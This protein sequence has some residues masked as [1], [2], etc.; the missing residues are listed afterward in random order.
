MNSRGEF[1]RHLPIE[2]R[3]QILA[4]NGGGDE[5]AR[6]LGILPEKTKSDPKRK[7]RS[8]RISFAGITFASEGEYKAF[9]Y[10]QDRY[11]AVFCHPKIALG[12][13]RHMQPDFI[14]VH[15]VYKDGTYH[16]ESLDYKGEWRGK[17][18]NKRAHAER[19]W[20]VRASWLKDKTGI[21]VRI[22]TN[23]TLKLLQR[24]APASS[25]DTQSDSPDVTSG[26]SHQQN[27]NANPPHDVCHVTGTAVPKGG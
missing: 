17:S 4:E 9:L 12:D 26:F 19:D 20:K 8:R 11:P 25:S 6:Q 24:S 23:S 22:I 5:L 7:T 15:E 14:V 18:G 2:R 21:V 16:A 10:L 27:R 3:K 1:L 13:G